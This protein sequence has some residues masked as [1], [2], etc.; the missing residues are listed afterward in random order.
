MKITL[1]QIVSTGIH[2]GHPTHLLNRKI[3]P[4]IYWTKTKNNC[5][6]IDLVKTRIQI[7]KVQQFLVTIGRNG[8]RVLFVGNELYTKQ[9]IEEAAIASHNFFVKERWL[10][11][12]LTNLPIIQKSLSRLYKL[13]LD[14]Q[15]GVWTSLP[16]KSVILLQKEIINRKRH[17]EG[18]KRIHSVPGVVIILNQRT[19]STAIRECQKL[20]I[21]TISLLD[22]DCDPNLIDLGIPIN[23]DSR[24][25]TRLFLETILPRILEGYR[26]WVSKKV[27]RSKQGLKFI[28]RSMRRKDIDLKVRKV[29]I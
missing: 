6:L 12:T 25:R 5:N 23:D 1:E 11:G 14:E 2:I 8:K 16:K 17:L 27:K 26:W 7:D 21:P 24:S 3:T 18:L 10:G 29:I 28:K 20:K 4:Y 9:T 13:E 15:Q 22:T 19:N